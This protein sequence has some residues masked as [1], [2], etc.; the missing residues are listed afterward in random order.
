[1]QLSPRCDHLPGCSDAIVSRTGHSNA[2][3][4]SRQE[5]VLDAGRPAGGGAKGGPAVAVEPRMARMERNETGKAFSAE[6]L[7]R[8]SLRSFRATR[9]HRNFPRTFTPPRA[10]NARFCIRYHVFVQCNI[11][12]L[13]R[14]K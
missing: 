13:R 12:L 9:R 2:K 1:M 4:S 10:T 8:M 7:P 3:W 5:D 14:S 6:K 11:S